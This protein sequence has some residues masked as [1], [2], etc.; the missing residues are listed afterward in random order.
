MMPAT[1]SP[2]DTAFDFETY[3]AVN[4]IDPEVVSD[5]FDSLV[6]DHSE[7][8]ILVVPPGN[9]DPHGRLHIRHDS[10]PE[11]VELIVASRLSQWEEPVFTVYHPMET[12]ILTRIENVTL[13]T[14]LETAV[15]IANDERKRHTTSRLSTGSVL[16]GLA[17]R[18]GAALPL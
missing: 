9:Y 18:L 8:D 12:D 3:C 1:T 14:A 13:G 17:A 7:W 10:F 15:C 16:R 6:G 2:N 5:Q 11:G 4:D